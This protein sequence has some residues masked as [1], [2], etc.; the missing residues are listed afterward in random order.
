MS[1]AA[2]P[3]RTWSIFGAERRVPFVATAVT[4]G[5]FRVV[6]RRIGISSLGGLAAS[7]IHADLGNQSDSGRKHS[8][9]RHA[10][11]WL[12]GVGGSLS[13]ILF[14]TALTSARPALAQVE[15]VAMR[16]TGISCGVCA[17]VSEINF[18]RL[19]GVDKVK[20][21]L[22]Q[23]AILLTY[24]PGAVFSPRQIRDLLRPL[25]VGVVQFQIGARGRIQVEGGKRFFVAGRDKFLVE[26]DS[27]SPAPLNT[28]IRVEAILND[29]SDPMEVKILTFQAGMP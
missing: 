4:T 29:H 10:G 23:E 11:G 18:K 20:I 3:G 27:Q 21:S 25:E 8:F 19:A 6:D 7:A 15:K 13:L 28:P 24:K 12:D 16:T 2:S 17:A 9:E 22:S 5:V 1:A 14:L 26:P